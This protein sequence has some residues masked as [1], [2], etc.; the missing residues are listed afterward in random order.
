M[1]SFDDIGLAMIPSGY[2]E[3]KLYSVLPNSGDG[4][5]DFSRSTTATRVN[6]EGL[7][8]KGRENLLLQSN[9][10]TTSPW[11]EVRIFS[12]TQ[13]HTGYDGSNNAWLI[14]PSSDNATHIKLQSLSNTTG[15][16][17]ISVYA[18]AAGY[19]YFSIRDDSSGNSYARFDLS[20]GVTSITG[21]NAITSKIESVGNDWWRCSLTYLE[22]ATGNI[23]FYV[24]NAYNF[25]DIYAGDEV[26]GVYFQDFQTEQ[27]LVATDV[28]ETTTT[29][30]YEGI[31]DDIPRLDYPIVNGAVRDCPALLLEPQRTN[32]VTYSEYFGDSSW[33][34]V[35]AS[36][37]SNTTISPSGA[38]NASTLVS[39]SGTSEQ[40]LDV[41]SLS[42]TSGE[43]YTMSVL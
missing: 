7:I 34:K 42:V 20:L 3:G 13:G 2:K 6:S 43:D 16:T 37:S 9:A 30:V 41:G 33:T 18:K 38:T 19:N 26:S 32:L 36:I 1:S 31:T 28:I 22:T 14:I 17:T 35:N 8:E 27:G 11:S 29:A 24:N 21:S 10:I 23:L 12:Q 25:A 39:T 15:V 5:F 40:Y 4:D